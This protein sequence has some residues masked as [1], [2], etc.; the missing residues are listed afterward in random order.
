MASLVCWLYKAYRIVNVSIIAIQANVRRM[1]KEDAGGETRLRKE[2]K[3]GE[4]GKGLR[5]LLPHPPL[6]NPGSNTE[7]SCTTAE[8]YMD[9]NHATV[10]RNQVF[11]LLVK[12]ADFVTDFKVSERLNLNYLSYSTGIHGTLSIRSLLRLCCL[13]NVQ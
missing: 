4:E 8:S 13:E 11:W 10:P 5:T 2:R 1:G 3:R 9:S 7:H 12:T 6:Q